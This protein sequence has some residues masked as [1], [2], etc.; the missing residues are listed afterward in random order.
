[1]NLADQFNG[2]PTG[3]DR[4]AL[5]A[6]FD[7]TAPAEVLPPIPAGEYVARCIAAA[8]DESRKGTPCYRLRLEITSGEHSGRRLLARWYLSPAALPYARRDLA[9]LG[10]CSFAQLERGETPAGLV[11]VRV[12]L[13]RDDSGG[14][15]NEVRA[16]LPY[17]NEA[18]TEAPAPVAANPKPEPPAAP[19][20]A[21]ELPAGLVDAGL[22]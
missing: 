20:T 13:R 5:G 8:L 18:N 19:V 4:A 12:A 7:T 15:F 6:A 11:R 9:A 22:M 2:T 21:D 3:P 10:L 1:M 14:A 16:V 17:P